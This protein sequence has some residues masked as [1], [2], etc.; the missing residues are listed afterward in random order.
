MS[1]SDPIADLLTRIRNGQSQ[2]LL[3][4][5]VLFSKLLLGLLQVLLQ[6]GYIAEFAETE[7]DGK[8]SIRV[9]LKYINR[10]PV[11]KQL[12]RVSKPGRRVYS[13]SDKLARHYNGLGCT[14]LTTP[15]GIM[16]DHQAR[17]ANVGGEVI[18]NIF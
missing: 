6:E 8:P 9:K 3:F 4:V 17:K 15:Q 1:L 2:R 13:G 16:A 12:K 7:K 11:I 10:L 18:C 14:I 5:D